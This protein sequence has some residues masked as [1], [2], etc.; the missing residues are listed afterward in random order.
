MK[1]VC[2]YLCIIIL[3]S[4]SNIQ[5]QI[6]HTGTP[7]SFDYNLF[8]N[9]SLKSSFNIGQYILPLVDNAAERR[10]TDSINYQSLIKL[11]FYGKTID[12][13]ID[14]INDNE[15]IELENG[16]LYL[17]H[18]Y[19]PG[20][21]GLQL[22]FDL[23]DIPK[24]SSLYVYNE[25]KDMVLGSFNHKNVNINKDFGTQLIKGNSI[26]IE[27]FEPKEAL[28]TGELHIN[29]IVYAFNPV[30]LKSDWHNPYNSCFED[31]ACFNN[32]E[33]EKTGASV[34][35]I[36][37][38]AQGTTYTYFCS[39]T[40]LNNALNNGTPYLLSAAHCADTNYQV[41]INNN[42]SSIV[43]IS[44]W[45]FLFNYQKKNCS[46]NQATILN[47]SVYGA[48]LLSIDPN[49]FP[50]DSTNSYI[51]DHLLLK[52]NASIEDL[53]QYNV[54]YAGWDIDDNAALNSP[55]VVSIHHPEGHAKSYSLGGNVFS[56]GMDGLN[57]NHW[58]T[59]WNIGPTS[60]GSSG[61]GLFDHNHKLIGHLH[62]GSS[63]CNNV[64]GPDYYNKFSISYSLGQLQTWLDPLHSN[65]TSLGSLEQELEN[66]NQLENFK[67]THDA[68][69]DHFNIFI[70]EPVSSTSLVF[71][72]V[73]NA[74]GQVVYSS[75]FS[76]TNILSF[77]LPNISTGLYIFQLDYNFK[78]EYRKK[79]LIKK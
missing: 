46:D 28:Q 42:D 38:V 12:A 39:G 11:D 49:L 79:M 43:D 78:S 32:V 57:E 74:I 34:A 10:K 20:A 13:D 68:S 62:G 9:N 77:E 27:Y 61:S 37:A 48:E 63:S 50:G 51:S 21:H 41:F 64:Y 30:F 75:R 69:F 18:I 76:G 35:L 4:V 2:Q 6:Y 26:I 47:N 16:R 31:L 73:F 70:L 24:G 45:I 19:A 55:S 59:Y 7:V 40:L 54:T 60:S 52:L 58:Q 25:E 53:A 65:I 56:G 22:Y 1:K 3:V 5:G 44:R 29:N 67:I 71:L 14:L 33:W 23:F 8:P 15:P 17:Y 36:L 66:K 72:K